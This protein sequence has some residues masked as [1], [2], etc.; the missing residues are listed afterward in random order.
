MVDVVMVSQCLEVHPATDITSVGLAR[1]QLF[2]SPVPLGREKIE[3]AE[4]TLKPLLHPVFQVHVTLQTS[5]SGELLP[6]S[7][8]VL[9]PNL[10]VDDVFVV[11]Q[12]FPRSEGFLTVRTHKW[13]LS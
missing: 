9:Q 5:V 13:F 11:L 6:T 3:P 7:C 2:M 10:G 1:S 12:T 4:F 8:T